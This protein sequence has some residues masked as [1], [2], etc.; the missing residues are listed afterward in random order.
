MFAVMPHAPGPADASSDFDFLIGR[1]TVQHHRLAERLVGCT[2]WVDFAGTAEVLP[3]LG[4]QANVDDNVLEL[5]EGRYR[6]ASLRA[7][8]PA[9]RRWSIWWL[10]GRTPG[11]LDPPVVGQFVDG[12][13]E[14]LAEDTLGGRPIV[15]R[16]RWT[17]TR[18]ARPRWEQAF[19]ADHGLT[20]EANW[21]MEFERPSAPA[22]A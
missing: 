3:L 17:E 6:A 9:S 13:G 4:G 16:F 19:S 5:P 20:W 22:R 12:V 21:R 18:T 11:H 10:D 1:W 7:Y 2:T 14:F 15:V 8:D